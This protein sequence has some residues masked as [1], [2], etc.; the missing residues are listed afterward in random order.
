MNVGL[1]IYMYLWLLFGINFVSCYYYSLGIGYKR[2]E[3]LVCSKL[4]G[5]FLKVSY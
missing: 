1:E 2:L 3:N 5:Y 4:L